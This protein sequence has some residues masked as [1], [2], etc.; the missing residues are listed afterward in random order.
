MI[1]MVFFIENSK[2]YYILKSLDGNHYKIVK[3]IFN[4]FNTGYKR[5]DNK[6]DIDEEFLLSIYKESQLLDAYNSVLKI[7]YKRRKTLFQVQCYLLKKGFNKEIIEETIQKLKEEGFIDDL[8]YIEDFIRYQKEEKLVS[9]I[10]LKRKLIYKLGK[11]FEDEKYNNYSINGILEKIYPL[12]DEVEVG[13]KLLE[14]HKYLSKLRELNNKKN[15][16][17]EKEKLENISDIKKEIIE[18]IKKYLKSKGFN[19]N[20]ITKILNYLKI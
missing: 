6:I 19:F 20:N 10:S 17:I 9:R 8:D 13:L 7:I 5:G 16:D 3:K 12:S 15:Q 18:E 11:N 4:Q 1:D 2:K 14:K